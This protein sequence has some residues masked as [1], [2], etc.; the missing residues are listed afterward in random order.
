LSYSPEDPAFS[1]V[2]GDRAVT[3][4]MGPAGA[5]FA[6]VAFLL[7]GQPAFLFPALVLLGGVL[8]FRS[9]TAP[10]GR[11]TLLFRS[12][13]FL[14]TIA[15][16]CGLATLHF[17]AP[18]M[19]ET[20]GGI[21]GQLVGLGLAQVLGLLGATLLLLVLWLA[22]VSL[23]TGVSWL[24]V[25]DHTGRLVFRVL[26]EVNILA[27]RVQIWLQGRRARAERHEVVTKTR[28][29]AKPAAPRIEP[30][31]EKLEVSERFERERQVPLF[32]PPA[33]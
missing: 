9:R 27:N 4:R 32:E 5:W 21:L 20:A 28:A 3:N 15:T 11:A 26:T 8:L 17:D 19:R 25:M 24:A 10:A 7:F 12:A 23:A 31:I 29:K 6:D 2:G 1:V 18:A 33:S 14:L 13:G 30:T 16:S 22:A